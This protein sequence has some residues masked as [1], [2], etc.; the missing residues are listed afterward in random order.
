M[1]QLLLSGNA[2]VSTVVV[3][4]CECVNVECVNCCCQAMRVCQLLLSGNASVST[5]VV[6]QCEC[7]NCCQAM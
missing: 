6:R 2:S 3:R 5:I 1:C 7:V 4:Q